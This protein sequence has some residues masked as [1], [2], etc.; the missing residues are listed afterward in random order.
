[1]GI[2]MKH[3]RA[4][5]ALLFA[6]IW[7]AFSLCVGLEVSVWF[8]PQSSVNDTV[9]RLGDIVARIDGDSAAGARLRNLVA[10]DAA[11]AG[12]SRLLAT[13]EL[14]DVRIAAQ[15]PGITVINRTPGRIR[16]ATEGVRH[17]VGSVDSLLRDYI[18]AHSAWPAHDVAVETINKGDAWTSLNKPL[19]VSVAG[20]VDPYVRGSVRLQLRVRQG[21]RTQVVPV[22]CRV[23]V[24]TTV[25]VAARSIANG[26]HLCADAVTL[27]RREVTTQVTAP[28]TALAAL[29]GLRARRTIPAATIV[30]AQM[31]EQIPLVERGEVVTLEASI[32]TATV[33]V[34]AV[35]R[36]SGHLGESVW[37]VN[38]QGNRLVRAVV[39]GK[40]RAA[41]VSQGRAL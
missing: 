30:H 14:C 29:E 41:V 3:D 2:S 33:S 40:S 27:E 31:I 24:T 6:G 15:V 22:Q 11:P 37:V 36:E 4:Q 20:T 18:L 32:G 26:E 7:G 12:F 34:H 28:L 1:M 39:T 9:I 25:V 23:R 35:A 13:D 8:R 17:T 10:G 21:T 19:E 38:E 16:I 5:A